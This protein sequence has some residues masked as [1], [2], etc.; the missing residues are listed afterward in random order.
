MQIIIQSQLAFNNP[1]HRLSICKNLKTFDIFDT[2]ITRKCIYPEEIFRILESRT[3]R[4]GI[5]HTRMLAERKVSHLEYTLDDI[6]MELSRQM[7]I[8]IEEASTIKVIEIEIELEN[9]VPIADEVKRLNNESVLISDMYLP[10]QV[11]RCMLKK[12]GVRDDLPIILSSAGKSSGILWELFHSKGI[13]CSHSGDNDISDVK[14]ARKRG[15]WARESRVAKLN[16]IEDAFARHG[17][18]A[19]ATLIRA[20]RLQTSSG[21]LP[22]WNARLQSQVNLPILLGCAVAI[23][24]FCKNSLRSS[25]AFSSRDTKN[26]LRLFKRL[27]ASLDETRIYS[28][29]WYSSRLTRISGDQGYTDYC[30]QSFSKDSLFIDLCGTGLSMAKLSTQFKPEYNST[31]MVCQYID[32][33]NLTQIVSQRYQSLYE[34]GHPIENIFKVSE[35]FN[36]QILELLNSIAEGMVTGVHNIAGYWIPERQTME[37]DKDT[38]SIIEQQQKYIEGLIDNLDMKIIQDASYEIAGQGISKLIELV[39][40]CMNNLTDDIKQLEQSL[41]PGHLGHDQSNFSI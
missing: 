7:A 14:E 5:A 40:T 11:I 26:L 27:C 10:K 41:L 36:N 29:Y 1:K 35:S 13:H 8:T 24:H 19:T 20:S 18:N 28:E 33:Q 32:D 9:V 4:T 25:L 23:H 21:E 37:Y 31:F 38:L 16:S 6:Y 30:C 39:K 12:A 22:A 2:L 15:M 3:G 17:F 34:S